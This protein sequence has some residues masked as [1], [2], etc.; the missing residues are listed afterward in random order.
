MSS[1]IE[2][3]R[4]RLLY[5]HKKRHAWRLWVLGPS[6]SRLTV[7]TNKAKWEQDIIT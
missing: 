1:A 6:N 2:R 7:Q 4:T 5:G 3:E